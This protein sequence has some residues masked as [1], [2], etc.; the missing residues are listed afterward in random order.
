MYFC[1]TR[2][3]LFVTKNKSQLMSFFNFCPN[4]SSKNFKFENNRRFECSDC[5]MVY[6]HNVAAAVAIIIERGDEILF[7]VRNNEPQ[8]G[9]LD[10]P[11]GFT[12]PNETAE[13]TCSREIKEE[14]NIDISPSDFKYFCSQPND[15]NYRNIPYKTEDL[16]FTAKFPESTEIKLEKSEIAD[17]KWINKREINIVE[18][19]FISLRKAMKAYLEK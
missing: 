4:C 8:K 1:E 13:E 17:Y 3:Y 5:K 14:L 11:G 9:K 16:I 18:I 6:F 15:Y 10:F 12:D 7:T 19:G 2:L